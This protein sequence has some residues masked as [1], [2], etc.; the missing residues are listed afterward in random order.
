[1]I[2]IRCSGLPLLF[3]CASSGDDEVLI[4][5]RFE[6]SDLGNAVHD[7]MEL[8]VV[9]M[10][11]DLDSLALR[12]AVDRD[13]LGRLVWYGRKAWAEIE[14]A[15]PDPRTE[16]PVSVTTD[17]FRLTG[18]IDILAE[19]VPREANFADWKSGYLDA[20]YVHQLFGYAACLIL[21]GKY[22]VVRGSVVWLRD[23]EIENYTFT[24]E[25]VMAWLP[26]LAEQ[27]ERRGRF[28]LGKHCTYCPRSHSCVAVI[29]DSRRTVATLSAEDFAPDRINATIA[30]LAPSDRVAIFREAKRVAALAEQAKAAI[31][32]NVIQ[33]GGELDAGDGWILRVVDEPGRRVL[34]TEKTWPILEAHLNEAEVASVIDVSASRFEEIVAKRAG[35][36]HGAKA[37]RALEDELQTAGA[38]SRGSVHKL[39]E[40]RKREET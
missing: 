39:V 37:K 19:P 29:Q 15:Y 30:S 21:S 17:L 3:S 2:S 12:W 36:G 28:T 11:P 18:H 23:Q 32:L 7:A 8:V 4:D 6:A 24:R 22:D 31:R 5:R 14:A 25:V 16:V 38:I 9:G 13:D 10:A 20:D 26:R 27:L 1:M 35:K 34:D 33:S 40:R